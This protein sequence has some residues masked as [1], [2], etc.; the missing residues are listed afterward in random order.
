MKISCRYFDEYHDTFYI[1]PIAYLSDEMI[2]S[3]RPK[4]YIHQKFFKF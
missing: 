1:E 2:G 4:E 3:N